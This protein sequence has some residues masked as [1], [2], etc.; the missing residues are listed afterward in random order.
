MVTDLMPC[1]QRVGMSMLDSTHLRMPQAR[2]KG[3]LLRLV[4][5]AIPVAAWRQALKVGFIHAVPSPAVPGPG[6]ENRHAIHKVADSALRCVGSLGR[7]GWSA[8]K[9]PE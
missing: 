9:P 5:I 3:E 6:V 4:G 1:R 2:F 8:G 7:D